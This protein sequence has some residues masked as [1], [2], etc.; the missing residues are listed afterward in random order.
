MKWYIHMPAAVGGQWRQNQSQFVITESV[1]FGQRPIPGFWLSNFDREPE[2]VLNG[3]LKIT[4]PAM[5]KR[6]NHVNIAICLCVLSPSVILSHTPEALTPYKRIKIRM[7]SYKEVLS[8]IFQLQYITGTVSL[9]PKFKLFLIDLTDTFRN[10]L[11]RITVSRALDEH[12]GD[13]GHAAG[14]QINSRLLYYISLH[15]RH[16]YMTQILYTVYIVSD[17]HYFPSGVSEL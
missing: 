9:A 11:S 7:Y 17:Y 10:S 13:I 1:P 5:V 8:F 16:K 6:R 15:Q 12:S 4:Q 14:Y 2:V 3:D